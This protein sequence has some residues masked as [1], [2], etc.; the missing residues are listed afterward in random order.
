MKKK[1]QKS[2]KEEKGKINRPTSK[3]DSLEDEFHLYADTNRKTIRE[4]GMV[5]MG[6]ILGIDI[7]SDVSFLYYITSYLS[8]S[9]STNAKQKQWM[10]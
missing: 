5:K 6:K 8:L 1:N 10:R 9:F 7:Y 3:T 2:T 4:D